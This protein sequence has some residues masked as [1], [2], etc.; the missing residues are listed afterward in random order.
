MLYLERAILCL[1]QKITDMNKLNVLLA[2][3]GGIAI[4]VA[5]GILLAPDKG[6]ETR[7]RLRRFAKNKKDELEE[8]FC[9]F[10][11]SKGIDICPEEVAEILE[12]RS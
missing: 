3:G 9:E 1:I 11:Q 6:S 8:Q 12:S 5:A 10:L 2:L 7:D 4:G